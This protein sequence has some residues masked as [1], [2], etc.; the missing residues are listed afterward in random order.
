MC[1]AKRTGCVVGVSVAVGSM[2]LG[3]TSTRAVASNCAVTSVGLTP[4]DDLGTG[5]YLGQ[6][7]GGLY[8]NG[9]NQPP[10]A[11]AAEGIARAEAMQALDG[12]GEPTPTGTIVLL[13][14][15]MSNTTQEFCS[16]SSAEP[17]D[18]W[19]FVGQAAVH[20]D[21]DHT[22]LVIVNGARGGQAASAWDSPLDTMYDDVRDN[23]LAP[24]GLTEKQVQIVWVKQANPGPTVSL[25][26][27]N[28]DAFQL[29]RS[30]AD[31][32]RAVKVRYPN[33]KIIFYSNRIYAG[34]A[35][36]TL[37]PEP[38]AYES[39]FAVK[40][41]IEA[42]IDQAAGGGIDAVAGD[43]D[44]DSV[45]PFLAW[46]PNLW[47][48]GLMPRSD[49]LVWT[50]A[51]MQNDGT[52]P[53]AAAE[54]KVGAMLLRFMI[55]SPFSAPWFRAELADVP[56]MTAPGMLLLSSAVVCAALAV[57]RRRHSGRSSDPSPEKT[58]PGE[59]L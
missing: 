50:C 53:A 29:K 51:D 31:I 48:D 49:G 55:D 25:P 1:L 44:F 12:N 13:S 38:Y 27:A 45:A 57:I 5:L 11:H 14:I 23:K 8:P 59:T 3:A 20:P 26:N 32:A 33:C 35:S 37:N 56:A 18:P 15:G 28:A 4:V 21:V 41:V 9:L 34:Y 30:L 47:A 6:F 22:T 46:G 39:G 43:L 19:T 42:Q 40:W 58:R 36:T 54:Q 16:Q 52:H 24:K 7:E 17:C 2:V 10:A